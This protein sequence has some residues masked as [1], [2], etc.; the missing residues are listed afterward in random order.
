MATITTS[1]TLF[2]EELV[3]EIFNKVR[4]HSA[5]AKLCAASPISFAGTEQF[6]FT[7][8]GEAEIVGEGDDKNPG[9]A[10]FS[11]VSIKPIKFVYQHR[12]T[13]EFVNMSEEE[14]LPY[15][16]TF[17]EGYAVKMARAHDIAAFHGINPRTKAAVA[18]LSDKNFDALL[19]SKKVTYDASHPDDKLDAAVQE[20]VEDGGI[21]TGIAMSPVFSAA[22]GAMKDETGSNRSLYPEFR[23][24]QNPAA[25]AGMGVDVNSTVNFNT[26]GDYAIVG[27]FQNAFRWGY[28][29]NI[30]IEVIPY[31]DPDGLGDLK[32]K[33]QIVLRAEAYIGWGILDADSFRLIGAANG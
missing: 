26:P 22:M 7:M 30:P 19:A 5:L 11:P 31:G 8:D 1:S 13:D 17:M 23:F 27:D 2:P 10:V 9:D 25:F 16:E 32:R 20:I 15:L 4:G 6:V 24:G 21:V 28:A 12:L 33:N 18:A 29:K 3:P 14:Q